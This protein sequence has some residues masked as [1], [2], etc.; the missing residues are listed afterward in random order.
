MDKELPYCEPCW[1]ILE[2]G[3]IPPVDF[4]AYFSEGL[5]DKLIAVDSLLFNS[6]DH[7]FLWYLKGHLEH[8]LGSIKRALRSINTS[9]SYKDDFGDAWIRLGLIY[10]DMHRDAEAVEHF[11]KG[12]KHPL[13]DPTN[14]VDAGSS[15]QASGNPRLSSRILL[16]ALDLVPDDDRT[17]LTL[18]KVLIQLEEVTEARSVLHQGLEK[19]PHN[20]EMLRAVAQLQLK[21]GDLDSAMEMYERILDQHPRDFEALLAM[22]EI[23]LKRGEL[24]HS[25][26]YYKEVR[27]L[28]LHITWSGVLKFIL[29]HLKDLIQRNRNILSYRE[30][31]RKE[32]ENTLSFTRDLEQKVESSPGPDIL[33]DM[34]NLMRMFENQRTHLREQLKLS[35]DLVGAAKVND[36]F[37]QHLSSKVADLEV[38][39]TQKR[40]FDAKEIALELSPF[41]T[42]LKEVD[43]VKVQRFKEGVLHRLTELAEFGFDGSDIKERLKEVDSLEKEGRVESAM[44]LLKE[45]EVSLLE[46]SSELCHAFHTDR[47]AQMRK[48]LDDSKGKFELSALARKMD[49]YSR[50][51]DASPKE[52]FD[53]YQDFMAI[54]EKESAG[55]FNRETERILQ[56]LKYKLLLIEKDGA[57]IS[58]MLGKVKDL[59]ER[60]TGM[61]PLNYFNEASRLLMEMDGLEGQHNVILVKQKLSRIE[62]IM[63]D[64]RVVGLEAEMS[65]YIDPVKNVIERSIAGGNIKLADILSSEL[66][67]NMEKLLIANYLDHLR[68]KAKESEGLVLRLKGLGV[69]RSVFYDLSRSAKDSLAYPVEGKMIDALGNVTALMEELSSFLEGPVVNE[70]AKKIEQCRALIMECEIYGIECNEEKNA[71]ERA[72]A[73]ARASPTVDLLEDTFRLETGIDRKMKEQLKESIDEQNRSCKK[74]AGELSSRGADSRRIMEILSLVNRSEVLLEGGQVRQAFEI[75]KQASASL[76][77]VAKLT[78][79]NN[80]QKKL[81][82]IEALIARAKELEIDMRGLPEEFSEIPE[83]TSE[84]TERSREL[85]DSLFDRVRFLLY[86][87]AEKLYSMVVSS[88]DSLGKGRPDWIPADL[89]ERHNESLRRLRDTMNKRDADALY[90]LFTRCGETLQEIRERLRARELME[91]CSVILALGFETKE[92]DSGALMAK[93]QEIATR[94]QAGNLEHAEEDLRDLEK[95]VGSIRSIMK[96]SK[97]EELLRQLGELDDF[98]VGVFSYIEGERFQGRKTEITEEIDKLMDI[99]SSVYE[100]SELENA[101]ALL[102]KVN[103][104]K[105]SIMTMDGEW[106]AGKRYDLIREIEAIHPSPLKKGLKMEM[107]KVKESYN[108]GDWNM[109]FSLFDRFEENLAEVD[110]K[111]R[112]PAKI[113]ARLSDKGTALPSEPP[114]PVIKPRAGPRLQR[115]SLGGIGKIASEA[116]SKH[117]KMGGTDERAEKTPIPD[118]EVNAPPPEQ[119]IVPPSE[120]KNLSGIAKLIAGSRIEALKRAESASLIAPTGKVEPAGAEKE[121][122]VMDL[123]DDFLDLDVTTKTSTTKE[124]IEKVR[125]RLDSLFARMPPLT[126]LEDSKSH[127]AEGCRSMQEGK[128]PKALREFKT[129]ISSAVKV[130]KMHADIGKALQ[131]LKVKIDAETGKGKELNDLLTLYGNAMSLYRS[132]N[133]ED[134]PKLIREIAEALRTK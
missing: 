2:T 43:P 95:E 83:L 110:W 111:G 129:A 84:N 42:D 44:F 62:S 17:L 12:L 91:R 131:K 101:D 29:G 92:G 88:Y 121:V 86:D 93:A 14:L 40:Y 117:M 128:S 123:M 122:Q 87:G 41:I 60:R 9:I 98:A 79:K 99:S 46:H 6:P 90:P 49:A 4:R 100:S 74:R 113:S 30:N 1:S 125:G 18:G 5:E 64:L 15:L 126:Q 35:Q 54:Y 124:D 76:D 63:S 106:R 132:G 112:A 94:V 114:L 20:E 31:L 21:E 82:S 56:E 61:S 51:V 57:N 16:R 65:P 105:A 10:S 134:T 127:Y 53:G 27:E 45:L 23:Q 130:C 69:E 97:I 71:I 37:H 119:P 115:G 38:C 28:D 116:F 3:G 13:I 81:Q 7:F 52:L 58:E 68:T 66:F 133:L 118:A 22:G 26:K 33:S 109:F 102:K 34:E 32:Y 103:S 80:L 8:E 75:S 104:L 73:S 89:R 96:M 24:G 39:I 11:E 78:V 70:I 19:Y 77:K 50:L 59:K 47:L 48:F 108:A 120:E 107:E 55:Y 85:V 36:S 25:I 67:D 72:E